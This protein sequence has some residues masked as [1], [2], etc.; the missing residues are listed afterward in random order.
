VGQQA[1]PAAVAWFAW[2]LIERLATPGR[3]AG[4]VPLALWAPVVAMA[5]LA[6]AAWFGASPT[7]R[8]PLV[9]GRTWSACSASIILC[10]SLIFAAT[11]WAL[12]RAAPTNLPR[13]GAIVGLLAGALVTLVY[14]LHCPELDALFLLVWIGLG[15]MLAAVLG[16][17][18]APR[19]MRW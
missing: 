15:M 19:W 13:T 4:R 18:L 2:R 6:A 7:D 14:A 1:W 10:A 16:V 9:T 17:V 5:A 12:E 11:R 3:G 8:F